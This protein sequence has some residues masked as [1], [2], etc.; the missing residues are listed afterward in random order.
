MNC[1]GVPYSEPLPYTGFPLFALLTLGGASLAA[2]LLLL[3]SARSRRRRTTAI[4]V[5]M[6]LLTAGLSAGRPDESS[7]EPAAPSCITISQTSL[8]NGLAP[9]VAPA[10]ITGLITNHWPETVFVTTVTVSVGSVTTAPGSTGGTCDASDL[11]L[12]DPEM[13]V[14]R[15]LPPGESAEFTGASIGFNDKPV[16]QDACRGALIG[17]EYVSA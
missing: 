9:G 3:I 12:L 4:A 1:E 8:M 2:G 7:A 16:N 11:I 15:A 5:A 14:G 10:A 6:I 17:L 13:P